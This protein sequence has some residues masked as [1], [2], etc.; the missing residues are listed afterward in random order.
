MG[1]AYSSRPTEEI[2]FDDFTSET[3]LSK[4]NNARGG[5]QAL[6]G[7]NVNIKNRFTLNV[8]SAL[9][10]GIYGVLS[11]QVI[12]QNDPAVE[13]TI[14]QDLPLY[15]LEVKPSFGAGIRYNLKSKKK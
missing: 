12:I 14:F 13:G 7:L 4:F 9:Y 11:E 3:A 6:F 1:I 5:V 15:I 10:G 8:F 2:S